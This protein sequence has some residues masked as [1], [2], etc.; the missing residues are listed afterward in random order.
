[1]IKATLDFLLR[2]LPAIVITIGLILFLLYYAVAAGSE[3]KVWH[4]V[5]KFIATSVLGAGVFS[6]IVKSLQF[7]K[8][9]YEEIEK[10]VF[11]EKFIGK[12]NDL[13]DIWCRL[14]EK[15]CNMPD[16][17]R[18]VGECASTVME[19]YLPISSDFYYDKLHHNIQIER[20][21]HSNEKI[22]IVY[23]IEFTIISRTDSDIILSPVSKR[24]IKAVSS[25]Q[26][27]VN[28]YLITG[29][30]TS[31][32]EKML[33]PNQ[34]KHSTS[35]N[36]DGQ[37]FEETSYG[38]VLSGQKKYMVRRVVSHIQDLSEDNIYNIITKKFTKGFELTIVKPRDLEVS[39]HPLGL[40]DSLDPKAGNG[41]S[42]L[43]VSYS[44]LIF[45]H[46]GVIL[47]F[48]NSR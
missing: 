41:P 25:Q 19:H 48:A 4:D 16:E 47:I 42:Q 2:Y 6:A 26:R 27:E 35:R 23:E 1:M 39:Y 37:E 44:K 7:S 46:Q 33:T 29:N 30:G 34:P 45:P 20:I 18:L 13:Q 17:H 36:H 38:I 9:F 12:R 32:S 11:G 28:F 21:A 15:I 24:N 22:K 43:S 40:T 10:V 3:H 14:T 8:I 31:R 5:I